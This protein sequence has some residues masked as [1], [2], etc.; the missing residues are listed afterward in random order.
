MNV[1][2]KLSRHESKLSTKIGLL[3]LFLGI[4]ALGS[5]INYNSSILALIGLSLSLWGALFLLIKPNRYIKADILESTL[6]S[7]FKNIDEILAEQ[8][9]HGKGVYLPPHSLKELKEG[10][11]FF[12]KQSEMKLP[13]LNKET[14]GKVFRNPEG[15]FLTP[16]GQGLIA[17]YEKKLGTNLAKVDMNFLKHK[18]PQLMIEDLELVE[19]IEIH[20]QGNTVYVEIKGSV[21]A[22]IHKQLENQTSIIH[23]IGCPLCSSIACALA[24]VANKS[25]I[26]EKSEVSSDRKTTKILYRL[27][28]N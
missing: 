15:I 13:L 24:K 1:Y 22:E 14:E 25:V 4:V 21:Y 26:I 9:C 28:K 11:V 2:S 8:N 7:N 5:S 18:L 19:D 10:I 17:L 27:Q 6:I 23:R 16:P 20:E 12:P 3:V